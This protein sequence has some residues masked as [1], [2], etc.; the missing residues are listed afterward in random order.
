MMHSL[1]FLLFTDTLQLISS[2][3]LSRG[4]VQ[5]H[6]TTVT[7]HLLVTRSHIGT[8]KTS[9]LMITTMKQRGSRS[10]E[11]ELVHLV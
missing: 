6:V 4:I 11:E 5:H 7:L 10:K 8:V 9:S 1:W 2:R 3:V